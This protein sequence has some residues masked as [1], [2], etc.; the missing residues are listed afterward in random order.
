MM[1]NE[2]NFNENIDVEVGIG[3]IGENILKDKLVVSH[4][5]KDN[6][7]MSRNVNPTY[8]F[9][10]GNQSN[11]K[12]A[13]FDIYSFVKKEVLEH[14][15]NYQQ[16]IGRNKTFT[17]YTSLYAGTTSAPFFEK[18]LSKR[19]TQNLIGCVRQLFKKYTRFSASAV[20][21]KSKI[22]ILN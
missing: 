5:C 3:Q 6:G 18:V 14:N 9:S 16:F 4:I 13:G 12:L 19:N 11:E 2:T 15:S 17:T 7:I 22:R 20:V 10:K 21:T 8:L 1:A